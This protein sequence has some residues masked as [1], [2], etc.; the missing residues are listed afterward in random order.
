MKY[1]IYFLYV[2]ALAL[3]VLNATKL[4]FNN[5]FEGDSIIAL[6]SMVSI[7]CGVLLLMILQLSRKANNKK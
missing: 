1:F 2:L 4:D 5:L 7:V 3:F 6:I